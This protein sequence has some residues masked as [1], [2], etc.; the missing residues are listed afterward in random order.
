MGQGMGPEL[1]PIALAA[2]LRLHQKQAD[3]AVF[4][5]VTHPGDAADGTA[6][7]TAHPDSLAIGMAVNGDIPAARREL[8]SPGPGRDQGQIRLGERA[9]VQA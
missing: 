3:E 7:K 4:G 1:P 8:F 9:N 2:V 6:I 5:V